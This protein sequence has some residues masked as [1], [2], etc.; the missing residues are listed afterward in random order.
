MTDLSNRAV[1][2]WH[3]QLMQGWD[4]G[5]ASA[6]VLRKAC[7]IGKLLPMSS[8]NLEY[9]YGYTVRFPFHHPIDLLR[10]CESIPQLGIVLSGQSC[11]V[12]T[13]TTLENDKQVPGHMPGVTMNRLQSPSL[14][15]SQWHPT[16]SASC[17]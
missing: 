10:A 11:G 4:W 16:S 8:A 5:E 17:P 15:V 1:A 9:Y 13:H 6:A 3:W 14:Q 2:F 12:H 7:N